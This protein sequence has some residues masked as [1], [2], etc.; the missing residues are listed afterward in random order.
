MSDAD[1][2]ATKREHQIGQGI[3]WL[4]RWSWRWIL[5]A[6]ATWILFWVVSRAW[7]IVLPVVLALI[8]STVLA[9][10]ANLLRSR[11]RFPAAIAA[12]ISLLGAVLLLVVVL[13]ALAP[14]VVNQAGDIAGDASEGLGKIETWLV[15]GPLEVSH[16][17]IQTAIDAA[18][19]RLASSASTIA[20]GVFTGVSA[21]TSVIITAAL[22]LVLTFFFVKDGD[23]FLPWLS[24]VTGDEAGGHVVEV[25]RRSYQAL[26]NFIRTQAIVSAVDAVLIGIGLVIVGVPLAIPLAILTFLGGFIPIVGA[27]VVGALAVLIALVS[28]G[29]TGA[30]IV[31]AIIVGVQQLEG[32][33]LSPWLQGKSMNLHAAIVLLSVTIGGSLFGIV[34]AFLAVPVAAV[35]A[36][37][38]RYI[39]EV[40]EAQPEEDVE[41]P[42]P[43]DPNH[44]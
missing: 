39:A 37:I 23:R 19:D 21:V 11:L 31:L 10:P 28:N 8:L 22:V 36:T 15:E 3:A 25:M 24:R 44:T 16:D 42:D 26:G 2:T 27:F 7:P 33:L 32:N 41:V 9:P 14:S 20:S 13:W 43:P 12:L 34:G 5:I 18:Q 1:V 35:A 17:Q 40:M 4:A 38:L 6:A 30:I 29:L